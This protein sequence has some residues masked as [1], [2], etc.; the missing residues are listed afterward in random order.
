MKVLWVV[1]SI[2]NDV[3]L[4]LYGKPAN[5]VWMDALLS[6][7]MGKKDHQIIV[8]TTAKRKELFRYQKDNV[9]YFVLPDQPPILYHENKKRN[10]KIWTELF[11]TVKPD[12]VQVWG[13]EFTPGLCALRIAHQK[14]I[15]AVIYM[16]GYLGSIARYYQAGI[17]RK[18]IKKTATFRDFI[19]HDG[20]LQQ[21]EK[22]QNSAKK[23]A[24]M[25]RL[26]GRIISENE[27]CNANIRSIVPEI[28][29]YHC[30]LSINQVFESYQ[31]DYK[32]AEP[33]SLICT[34]SGYT[35]KGLHMVIRAVAL[36]Q[37]KYPDIK[38]YVPGAPQISDGSLQWKIRKNGYTNYIEKLIR[39]LN[40][41][42][43]IVWL[44]SLS[45]K[46]LAEEYAKKAVF[47]MPS[48]IENHSSSL[49]EAM[50]VGMPCISSYVG[51]V[52]E[53][54]DHGENGLLYR[55]EEY[56]VLAG[57]IERLFEDP[58]FAESLSQ[59]ARQSMKQ[60]HDRSC[61]VEKMTNIYSEILKENR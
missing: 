36:L 47:V 57:W 13:T 42:D 30:P 37:K 45:Q 38:L 14:N 9:T 23:E 29:I 28:K 12:L 2:L 8:A 26:A 41:A 7:F 46:Q 40:V 18:E 27:W 56:E 15:P 49:K 17:S 33:H 58:V 25:L 19:R 54:V 16:Q 43:R 21:Q 51:G 59:S 5:G 39:K 60:L 53:Y 22:Y 35:I 52:P 44:G 11:D 31:W 20:I 6:D 34:A 32:N 10:I 48:A 61:L 50:T 3:S 55:F 24:E 4:E 1:N